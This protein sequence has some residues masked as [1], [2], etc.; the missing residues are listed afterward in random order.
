MIMGILY[1]FLIFLVSLGL[2]FLILYIMYRIFKKYIN[3]FLKRIDNIVENSNIQP[4]LPVKGYYQ[5][6]LE[7]VKEIIRKNTKK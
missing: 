3:S 7:K 6:E 5:Q 1:A 2:N 4:K